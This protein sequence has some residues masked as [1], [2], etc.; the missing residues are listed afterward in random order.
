MTNKKGF[1]FY[2]VRITFLHLVFTHMF[3]FDSGKNRGWGG[4]MSGGS[5]VIEDKENDT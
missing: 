4:A 5:I 3:Y 1:N 2:Y